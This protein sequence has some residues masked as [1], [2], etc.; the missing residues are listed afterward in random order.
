MDPHVIGSHDKHVIQGSRLDK[1]EERS[2]P[3][4][5]EVDSLSIIPDINVLPAEKTATTD[6]GVGGI[7]QTN[8]NNQYVITPQQINTCGQGDVTC[9]QDI[10]ACEQTHTELPVASDSQVIAAVCNP[11]SDVKVETKLPCPAFLSLLPIN[12]RPLAM[13]RSHC[14]VALHMQPRPPQLIQ[15]LRMMFCG[16][17]FIQHIQALSNPPLLRSLF[18]V[19][20]STT[21]SLVDHRLCQWFVVYLLKG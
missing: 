1:S 9:K 11:A 12:Y 2:Q 21:S 13:C 16:T 20:L 8:T 14:K 17:R 18:A 5:N 7:G 4:I 10:R 19:A 3:S 15:L 6:I